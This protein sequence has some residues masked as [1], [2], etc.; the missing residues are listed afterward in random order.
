MNVQRLCPVY[1]KWLQLNPSNARQHRYAMQAQTQQA[2]QQGKLDY[3]RELG[4][5]TFEAAKVILNALQPTSSQKVSV[6]QEDVLAFGTMGMYLSSLLAQEHK[7]QESHAILQ[8]C[9]QQLIAILPLHATNPSVCKLIA[10]IQH[11]VEQTY[12]PQNSRQL[13]SAALH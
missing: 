2:H 7:K 6:V 3:A 11:T 13:A 12:E 10:A 9:Q 5:Q 1:R 4:Y 8:E